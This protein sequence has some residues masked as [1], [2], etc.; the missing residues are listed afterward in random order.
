MGTKDYEYNLDLEAISQ[1]AESLE[2]QLQSR[3]DFYRKK[4]GDWEWR[5]GM[6]DRIIYV[7]EPVIKV[8]KDREIDQP[9]SLN[10]FFIRR[11]GIAASDIIL[12]PREGTDSLFERLAFLLRGGG[13]ILDVENPSVVYSIRRTILYEHP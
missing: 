12:D 4:G 8:C 2:K 6:F 7:L 10:G 9:F 11:T 5:A 1:A 3:R 13:D